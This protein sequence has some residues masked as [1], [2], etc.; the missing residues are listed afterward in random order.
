MTTTAVE[1]Q[2]RYLTINETKADSDQLVFSFS[3]ETPVTRYFGDEVLDHDREAVDL[4]RLNFEKQERDRVP[5]D[6]QQPAIGLAERVLKRTI[7]NPAPV[8]E[9][10]LSFAGR[11]A[12]G[13]MRHISPDPNSRNVRLHPDQL[14][15]QFAAKEKSQSVD[16]LMC[17]GEFMHHTPVVPEHEVQ[18]RI[19]QRD[20]RELLRDVAELGRGRF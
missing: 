7:L 9:Q 8:E 13:R 17:R 10:I 2:R 1:V 18:V 14:V 3:S 15:R 20:P 11:L 12:L 5:P 6:H 19:G 4:T 16:Q